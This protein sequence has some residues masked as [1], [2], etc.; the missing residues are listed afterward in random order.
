[1]DKKKSLLAQIR[2]QG[3]LPLFFDEDANVSVQV[4]LALYN[5]GVRTVEY[6]NRGITALENF[7]KMRRFCDADMND[8]RLGIGT[9]KDA[10]AAKIFIDEGADFIVSPGI[11]EEVALASQMAGVLWIPGCMTPS[12]IIRAE[13]TGAE[14]IKLF[15]GNILGPEFLKS[16]KVLFPDLLFMPT[17]GVTLEKENLTEWFKAGAAMVG[18]GSKLI[19]KQLLATKNYVEIERQT[20]DALQLFNAVSGNQ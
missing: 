12:E 18:I 20:K 11:V 7:K 16:V 13:R 5:A 6:T 1:M 2:H 15:P 17:G 19:T 14:I 10:E 4:L 3:V 8:M 9:I